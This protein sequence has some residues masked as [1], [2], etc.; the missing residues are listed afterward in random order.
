[1]TIKGSEKVAVS[2]DSTA[3]E[4]DPFDDALL[5]AEF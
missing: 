2:K 3:T 4:A 5:K 1:L